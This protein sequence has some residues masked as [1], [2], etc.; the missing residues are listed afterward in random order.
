MQ[1]IADL[2]IGE[3]IPRTFG[4]IMLVGYTRGTARG[5]F[6]TAGVCVSKCIVIEFHVAGD[7]AGSVL[8]RLSR[9]ALNNQKG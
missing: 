8:Y 9:E 5:S 6:A 1:G 2:M 3:T 4:T 7:G